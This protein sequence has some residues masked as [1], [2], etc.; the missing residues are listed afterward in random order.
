MQRKFPCYYMHGAVSS[1]NL[2]LRYNVLPYKKDYLID[3]AYSI[4]NILLTYSNR[5]TGLP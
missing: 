4:K 1:W 5:I 2:Q 3:I